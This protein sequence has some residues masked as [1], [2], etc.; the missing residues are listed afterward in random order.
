MLFPPHFLDDSVS[1]NLIFHRFKR[2]SYSGR[3]LDKKNASSK[4]LIGL[5]FRTSFD[6]GSGLR[7]HDG[8]SFEGEDQEHHFFLK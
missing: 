4:A 8:F 1:I 3:S 2:V 6:A 7:S 5:F